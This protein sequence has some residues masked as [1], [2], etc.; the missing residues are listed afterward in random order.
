MRVHV[1]ERPRI[2][3]TRTSSGA[4][5][6]TTFACAAFQRSRPSSAAFLSGELAIV[7]TGSFSRLVFFADA[8]V[9]ARV[10]DTRGASPYCFW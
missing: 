3:S 4:R 9:L 8:V 1:V 5:C 6:F 10:G 2:E 7:M